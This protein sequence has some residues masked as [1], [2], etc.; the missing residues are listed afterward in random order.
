MSHTDWRAPE[1]GVTE[2]SPGESDAGRT[3]QPDGERSIPAW[4]AV[5]LVAVTLGLMVIFDARGMRHTA[6]GMP[7]GRT[8]EFILAAAR[9]ADRLTRAAGLRAPG[10]WLSSA[11]GHPYSTGTGSELLGSSAGVTAP[12]VSAGDGSHA[13]GSGNEHT[14]PRPGPGA[15]RATPPPPRAAVPPPLRRPTAAAPLRLLVTGDSLTDSISPPL[16][17]AAH[18]TIHVDIATHYGT[19]LV[20]PDYF[21]WAAAARHELATFHPE[22][23][24][25]A[26]GANDAQ[27]ITMPGGT[28]LPTGTSAWAAEYTRRAV[29]FMRILTSDGIRPLYWMSLPVARNATQDGYYRDLNAAILTASRQVPRVMIV[30]VRDR[31]SDHGRYA[32]YLRDGSGHLVLARQPDGVHLTVDGAR[33]AAAV[34][35]AAI[36]TAWHLSR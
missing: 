36:G 12:A 33:I 9:P 21:D 8:R 32:A 6:E 22:A 34:L 25:L 27:G 1:P 13:A 2:I 17:E 20:R 11:L 4:R 10:A 28:V 16:V 19:G 26:L 24:L 31:L 15:R 18:G 35:A 7:P 23:V 30:D 5:R 14:R 29:I 3:G